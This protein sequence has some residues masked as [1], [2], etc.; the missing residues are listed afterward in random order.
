M[1]DAAPRRNPL[2]KALSRA[3]LPSTLALA[4]L[5]PGTASAALYRYSYYGNP[6]GEGQGAVYLEGN[7][8]DSILRVEITSPTRLTAGLTNLMN[9]GITFTMW[10]D[11]ASLTY[12]QVFEPYLEPLPQSTIDSC[13]ADPEWCSTFYPYFPYRLVRSDY[14]YNASIFFYEL[15]T[16]GA[17]TLWSLM[18]EYVDDPVDDPRIYSSRYMITE[19]WNDTGWVEAQDL[20]VSGQ[21]SGGWSPVGAS[22][23]NPGYWALEILGVPEPS[24]LALALGGLVGLIGTRRK[25]STTARG[26]PA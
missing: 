20:H 3:I 9:P 11:A 23:G 7:T 18:L 6:Y 17:P 15:D 4:V 5:L 13:E 25:T 12:E 16:L 22:H 19:N 2:A 8:A 1:T 24:A 14:N 10:D 21:R 26:I